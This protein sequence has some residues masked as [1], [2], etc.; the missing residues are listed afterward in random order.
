MEQP[1]GNG[2]A[3][4]MTMQKVAVLATST[5]TAH[6]KPICKRH[7]VRSS[8]NRKGNGNTNDVAGN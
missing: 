4:A 6:V 7:L 3:K 5:A 2:S 1:Y 8:S